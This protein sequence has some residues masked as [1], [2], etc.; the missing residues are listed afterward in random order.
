MLQDLDTL[1]LDAL[2]RRPHPTHF[3]L[4]EAVDAI[5]RLKPRRAF[6]T[7]MAHD[8]AHAETEAALPEHIRLA[9]DGLEIEV[10]D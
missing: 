2:R 6:L 7:H 3:S 5:E 8:L 4:S 1:V 10:P 9:Y